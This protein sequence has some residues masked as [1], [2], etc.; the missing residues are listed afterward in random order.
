MVLPLLFIFIL[1]YVLTLLAIAIFYKSLRLSQEVYCSSL[2]VAVSDGSIDLHNLGNI[3][4]NYLRETRTLTFMRSCYFCHILELDL[5][6]NLDRLMF[7]FKSS[8]IEVRGES[9]ENRYDS[10]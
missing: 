2:M 9:L 8:S 7:Q 3:D 6:V 5:T 4:P 1:P 10:K